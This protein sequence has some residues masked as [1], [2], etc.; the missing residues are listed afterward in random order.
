MDGETARKTVGP[1][2]SAVIHEIKTEKKLKL[3]DS[4]E[5]TKTE[6]RKM[7]KRTIKKIKSPNFKPKFIDFTSTSLKKSVVELEKSIQISSEGEDENQPSEDSELQMV[8]SLTEINSNLEEVNFEESSKGIPLLNLKKHES[9]LKSFERNDS[10]VTLGTF[11]L[12]ESENVSPCITQR[13]NNL[14]DRLKEVQSPENPDIKFHK[15]PSSLSQCDY[16]DKKDLLI[17]SKSHNSLS[18]GEKGTSEEIVAPQNKEEQKDLTVP[19]ITTFCKED[20]RKDSFNLNED[21]VFTKTPSFHHHSKNSRKC[22]FEDR[23]RFN[24]IDMENADPY[25]LVQKHVETLD[26]IVKE[27]FKKR[28]FEEVDYQKKIT[29]E[30]IKELSRIVGELN[31]SQQNDGN[32]LESLSTFI[33]E[34]AYPPVKE[35]SRKSSISKKGGRKESTGANSQ[36]RSRRSSRRSSRGSYKNCNRK[37][38]WKGERPSSKEKLREQMLKRLIRSQQGPRLSKG[39]LK[40]R[41]TR[42]GLGYVNRK[43]EEALNNSLRF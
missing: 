40:K 29:V 10:F 28:P 15:P 30:K 3:E 1:D 18:K 25:I 39:R 9:D 19:L 16:F 22:S 12:T 43:V 7:T 27:N 5:S 35:S 6:K 42:Q 31:K 34:P 24:H 41:V 17:F 32:T 2:G 20:N 36:R 23:D 8:F 21:K 14:A 11:D 13:S 26:K 33:A 4:F 38:K 37:E